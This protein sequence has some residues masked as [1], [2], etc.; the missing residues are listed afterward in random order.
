MKN[1]KILVTGCFGFLAGHLIEELHERGY[2]VVGLARH[3]G[4]VK[5]IVKPDILY[6]GD[7]RD[8]EFVEKAVSSSDGVINI[9]G[10]LGT[11]ETV[12]NPYPS[13]EVNIMGALNVLEA[14]RIWKLP[15]VQIAVGNHYEENS[16][17]ITKTTAERF[18]RMYAREHGLQANIVRALNAFGP[19]QKAKPVRKIIPSFITRALANEPIQIYGDGEQLMD[20]IYVKDVAN[21]LINVLENEKTYGNTFEAGTGIGLSVKSIAEK[22]IEFSGSKSKIEFLPMRPGETPN[23]KVIAENPYP[24]DY[25]T[26]EKSLKLTINSYE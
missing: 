14:C 1:K 26:F 3:M 8:K 6:I 20:M 19:R 17:S 22:I 11:Q 5:E 2:Q 9:G 12:N 10:I 21:I 18:T 25:S 13:V 4:E 16:Y 15:M 23:A 24:F 7:L